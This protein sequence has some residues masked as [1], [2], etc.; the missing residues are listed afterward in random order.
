MAAARS[1]AVGVLLPLA[2]CACTVGPDF[3]RPGPPAVAR[4]TPEPLA[5]A[6]AA[7]PVAQGGAQR[8]ASGADLQGDWWTLFRSA[9]LDGL[10]AD[11][12][13]ANP[14]LEAARAALRAARE[15]AAAARGQ[16]LPTVDAG[17]AVS[18]QK[19]AGVLASPLANND[20]IFTLHTAQLSVGYVP[21]VFGGLRREAESA[22][23]QAEAQ[24]FQSEAAYL[25]LTSNLVAAVIQEA[26][27]R[28]QIA[29][30][31]DL[32]RAQKRALELMREQ[33]RLGQIAR[34]D[35]AAQEAQ[36]AQ[37]EQSLPPLQKQLATQIDLVADLIGRAPAEAPRAPVRLA[38]LTLPEQLPVSLPARLAEQRPDVR[39][40]EANLHA[41]SAQV[42]V[43]IAARLPTFPITA[44][45][46]GTSTSLGTLF[47]NGNAFWIVTGQV[48][49]PIFHGGQLVHR[50]RAAEASL[51]QAKAQY[52]STVLTAFQNV[53]DALQAIEIDAR[54]LQAAVASERSAAV[55]LASAQDQF[56]SG[57]A[58]ALAVL[59]AEQTH[60][61][62]ALAVIQAR[63]ARL[64]DTAAL[65]QALGGGWWN[66]TDLAQADQVSAGTAGRR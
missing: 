19:T 60:D 56:R 3:H 62:A 41:A 65:F 9:E 63:A 44:G 22:E 13:K 8:F 31:D 5:A 50:Q 36:V 58:S 7:S 37:V 10:L 45:L 30:T 48:A 55:S 40:A 14:D 6:T 53:A 21:D 66:R 47:S 46:G 18:P 43:A 1:R 49:Q 35:L 32:I 16:L 39:A 20:N 57:Q 42:G 28:E 64:A 11:A 25:T 38:D 12:L 52:R 54:T 51:D 24:R 33:F 23:A 29:A 61:Q 15:T 4:F 2:L 34:Q 17:L 27:L 26:S 59:N